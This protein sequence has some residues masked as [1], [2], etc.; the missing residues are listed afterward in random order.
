MSPR[1][2]LVSELRLAILFQHSSGRLLGRVSA[3]LARLMVLCQGLEAGRN[4]SKLRTWY[5]EACHTISLAFC[6]VRDP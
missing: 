3:G 2:L 6:K 4:F 5:V 1:V